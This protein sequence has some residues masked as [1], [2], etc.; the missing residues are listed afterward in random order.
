MFWR[1]PTFPS[2]AD[3]E[4]TEGVIEADMRRTGDGYKILVDVDG[5]GIAIGR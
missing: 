3:G 4:E 1:E 5:K 2:A